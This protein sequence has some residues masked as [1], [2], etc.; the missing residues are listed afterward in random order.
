V[1]ICSTTYGDLVCRGCKR[2][3]HEI[4]QW[5]GYAQDQRTLVWQRL[6]KLREGAFLT[7]AVISRPD[8]LL[9]RA[10]GFHIADLDTLSEINIAYEVIRRAGRESDFEALGIAPREPAT[11]AIELYQRIEQ[12]L[13]ARS[14]AQYEHD[15]HVSAQ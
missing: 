13:Y 9:L 4:V 15:F 5:N 2:Y 6:F 10:E 8:Q 3:A 14:V 11:T 7:H 12:E 1:G